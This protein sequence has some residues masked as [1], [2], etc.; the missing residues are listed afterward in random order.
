MAKLNKQIKK[1]NIIISK[2]IEIFLKLKQEQQLKLLK[3]AEE[4]LVADKR[5][6]VRK[7][8][9]IPIHFASQNQ[10]F[11]DQIK[12][13]SKSGL[14]IET[15]RPLFVGERVIMSFNMD[16]YNRPFKIRGEV[17][18]AKRSGVGVEYRD[19]SPYIADM[20]GA[21]VDKI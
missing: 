11:M 16:G 9:L 12:D 1:Y 14:F 20:I 5:D 13:I 8:C 17:M 10:I 21:L 7:A 19:I 6:S 18:H 3:Y 2:L 15:A 4:L